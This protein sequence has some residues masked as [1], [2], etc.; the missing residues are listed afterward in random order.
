MISK[1]NKLFNCFLNNQNMTNYLMQIKDRQR[2]PVLVKMTVL[3][4][5]IQIFICTVLTAQ[6]N[7]VNLYLTQDTANT[8]Q[9]TAYPIVG[10][11]TGTTYGADDWTYNN[12]KLNLF[13]VVTG[14]QRL[15]SAD[16]IVKWD[17]TYLQ[18]ESFPGNLFS[19]NFFNKYDIT[20][21]RQRINTAS[22][23]G[24]VLA[25]S[26]KYIVKLTFNVLKPGVS[27]VSILNPDIRYYD[28]MNDI[29]ITIP[30]TNNQGFVKFYAGDF[31]KTRTIIY[32]G[33]G[34]INYKDVAMFGQ[35]YGGVRDAGLVYRAKYDIYP[36]ENFFDFYKLPIG[37]GVIDFYDMVMFTIGYNYEANGI[38]QSPF[39]P[40][41]NGKEIKVRLSKENNAADKIIYRISVDEYYNDLM[42][43]SIKIDYDV[44]YL[45][46]NGTKY[47][48]KQND[49]LLS[50]VIN[51]NGKVS[52]DASILK[53]TNSSSPLSGDIFDVAFDVIKPGNNSQRVYITSAEAFDNKVQSFKTTFVNIK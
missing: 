32:K 2:R 47:L 27:G 21:G 50:G 34:D 49:E 11:G 9:T 14:N 5:L 23:S 24:N 16:F 48:G 36:T 40:S 42:A 15:L 6:I 25:D 41:N 22:L 13:V 26:S 51:N 7:P 30:V 53:N 4:I 18:L 3:L 39:V 45:K 29:Q 52:V 33:D 38:I 8:S 37:D 12:I 44:N 19:P 10:M 20:T 43:I 28:E 1:L 35:H 46:F 17:S 31:A